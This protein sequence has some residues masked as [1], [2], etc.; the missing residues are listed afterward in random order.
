MVFSSASTLRQSI[1]FSCIFTI[2]SPTQTNSCQSS[3][4]VALL[5]PASGVAV[6]SDRVHLLRRQP[7][8]SLSPSRSCCWNATGKASK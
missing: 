7:L 1:D 8:L 6:A 3:V 4:R 2:S 5:C